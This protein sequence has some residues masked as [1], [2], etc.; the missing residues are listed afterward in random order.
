MPPFRMEATAFWSP[1]SAANLRRFGDVIPESLASAAT[2]LFVKVS[3]SCVSMATAAS[4]D[5]SLRFPSLRRCISGFAWTP[6]VIA[7]VSIAG[8]AGAGIEPASTGYEPVDL[9][10]CPSCGVIVD[11]GSERKNG[12][13][14]RSLLGS[15][16]NC[17]LASLI[18]G[19]P[20]PPSK[21]ST[22]R[23]V[24]SLSM[25]SSFTRRTVS[26][27]SAVERNTTSP[28]SVRRAS[29]GTLFIR[30]GVGLSE[31]VPSP[32]INSGDPVDSETPLAAAGAVEAFGVVC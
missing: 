8:V 23:A 28:L 7:A 21:S 31:I 15:T 13:T 19:V 27:L 22:V 25:E 26:V 6:A 20:S 30:T 14:G 29:P 9:A 3:G 2:S 4:R 24:G 12:R 11:C 17:L 16:E 32:A 5:T 18:S 10:V 1:R